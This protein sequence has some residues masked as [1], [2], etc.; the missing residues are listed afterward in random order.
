MRENS[1]LA[2]FNPGCYRMYV[3]HHTDGHPDSRICAPMQGMGISAACLLDGTRLMTLPIEAPV[4]GSYGALSIPLNPFVAAEGKYNIEASAEGYATRPAVAKDIA[5]ASGTQDFTPA[6]HGWKT[7][8]ILQPLTLS[9]PHPITLLAQRDGEFDFHLARGF[10]WHRVGVGIE[11][12]QQAQA[13]ALDI[14]V[15]LDALPVLLETRFGREARHANINARFGRV[16]IR[17]GL[18]KTRLLQ[19]LRREFDYVDVVVVLHGLPRCGILVPSAL[20]LPQNRLE[21]VSSGIQS[22]SSNSCP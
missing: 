17:I 1:R 5:G 3:R 14:A 16:V 22:R 21:I 4:S 2:Q 15:G 10:I 6:F 12:R 18:A 19:H 13:V 11:L 7:R 9:L 8:K 20:R